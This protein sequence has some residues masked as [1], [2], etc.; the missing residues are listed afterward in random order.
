MF[1]G[2]T[3]CT[4][5]NNENDCKTTTIDRTNQYCSWT[6]S[7]C[8]SF[9]DDTTNNIPASSSII[10]TQTQNTLNISNIQ[11]G[12]AQTLS[13]ISE[14]QKIEKDYFNNLEKGL[15]Q[16]S[17]SSEEKDSLVQKINQVSQMRTNL[18][19]NL[20]GMYSFYNSN[21]ASTKDTLEEQI[22]A[23]DIVEKELNEA[24][25]RMKAIEEEKYNK[26]RL[27]EIN[28][29]YGQ[30]YS[31][32]SSIMKIIIMICLPVLVLTILLN[33]GILPKSLYTVLTIIIVVI[34][35]IY[36]WKYIL[37]AVNRDNMNYQEYDWNFQS[38]NAP[39]VDT[40]GAGVS[41]PWAAVSLTCIGSACCDT[42]FSYDSTVNKCI[43]TPS[44][45]TESTTT[46]SMNN[47]GSIIGSNGNI[48]GKNSNFASY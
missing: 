21:I 39:E 20:N 24:K 37:S 38:K 11:E 28:S 7:G 29:Y 12:K 26:L 23:I 22:T 35:V 42:G 1:E 13:D 27:V 6:N 9:P 48:F 14:L 46:E 43:L 4:Q 45:T 44:T 8:S 17:I 47:M 34:G 15:A 19:K 31:Q 32:H 16:E 41:D 30:Q 25:L 3:N 2:Y 10:Q 33:R 18:Y 40:S 5:V 36:L